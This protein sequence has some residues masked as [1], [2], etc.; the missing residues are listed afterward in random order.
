M[1]YNNIRLTHIVR[2]LGGYHIFTANEARERMEALNTKPLE[3]EKKAVEKI[4]TE[5][6]NNG[7]RCCF[8]RFHIS[9]ATAEWLKSLGYQFR[10]FNR[11]S[12]EV[13]W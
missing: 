7:D 3:R 5:A 10:W 9:D 4:I 1:M 6:V 8:L 11:D 13:K 12:A 2:F